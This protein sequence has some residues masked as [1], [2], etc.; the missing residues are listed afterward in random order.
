VQHCRPEH[1][2]PKFHTHEQSSNSHRNVFR[3]SDVPNQCLMKSNTR[4]SLLQ[5]ST[6]VAVL[7]PFPLCAQ[8]AGSGTTTVSVSVGPEAS[9]QV[10]TATTTLTAPGTVFN[11]Y[12]GTTALTYKIRTTQS[13]GTGNI[14]LEVTADFA[15]AGGPSVASPPTAGDTL[16]YT[17]TASAPATA[18][19]G[20]QTSSTTAATSVA[21][22]GAGASSAVAGNSASTSWIL[23]NDPKYHTGSYS[24]TVTYTISAT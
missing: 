12:T 13:T 4:N 21:T 9:I 17:C 23:V 15:P 11:N 20:S 18:C 5:I 6:L 10:D 16:T 2:Q 1:G 7:L 19:S 8:F 22:F 24:A 14:Q 3:T